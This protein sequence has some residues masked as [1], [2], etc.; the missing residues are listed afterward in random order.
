[1]K[2]VT[3]YINTLRVH[4][5]VEELERM[6]VKE[7]MVTEFFSPLSRISRMQLLCDDGVTEVIRSVVH[8]VGTTG[9][10]ADHF[11]EVSDYDPK[12]ESPQ[13]LGRRISKLED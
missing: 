6:G 4:W 8:K 12:K 11:F 9:E 13:P 3:A 5:L 7:I 2:K 10:A 1:M